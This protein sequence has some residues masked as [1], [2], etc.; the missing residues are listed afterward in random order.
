[1][2]KVSA[3]A[4]SV[5]QIRFILDKAVPGVD[6]KSP[7]QLF[8]RP[9]VRSFKVALCSTES[10]ELQSIRLLITLNLKEEGIRTLAFRVALWIC[11]KFDYPDNPVKV[12]FP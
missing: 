6:S 3:S 7:I 10:T 2:G 8:S 12:Q 11:Y 5:P 4:T 9:F 1:M